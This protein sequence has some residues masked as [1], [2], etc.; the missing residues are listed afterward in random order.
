[1]PIRFTYVQLGDLEGGAGERVDLRGG[2][3]DGDKF[4]LLLGEKVL[5]MCWLVLLFPVLLRP[6]MDLWDCLSGILSFFLECLLLGDLDQYSLSSLP[7][8]LLMWPLLLGEGAGDG[9]GDLLLGGGA[10]DGEGDLDSVGGLDLFLL[11]GLLFSGVSSGDLSL[12]SC[13]S[14]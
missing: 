9:E 10:G 5:L 7:L 11:G 6:G 12:S 1:L 3:G 14:P 13:C 4:L 8:V 2:E